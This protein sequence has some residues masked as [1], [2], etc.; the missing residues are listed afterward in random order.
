M[1]IIL[2]G[3]RPFEPG[4]LR[5]LPQLERAMVARGFDPAECVI[6]K[7]FTAPATLPMTGPLFYDYSVI[8]GDDHFTVTESNDMRF[9]GCFY[10]RVLAPEP[11]EQ[12]PV[13][14]AKTLLAR[15]TRW[16]AQPI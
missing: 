16:M 9:L 8:V 2:Q 4:F 6:A 10:A 1:S 14:K 15:F 3:K 11:P 13:R 5:R 12:A 7:D